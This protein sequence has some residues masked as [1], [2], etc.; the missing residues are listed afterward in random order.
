MCGIAAFF[1]NR[2][3][4][5]L[6]SALEVALDLV[7]HRGP[8]GRGL[9][10][11]RGLACLPNQGNEEGDW[12]LGHV[13]LSILDLTNSGA[14]PMQ[15]GGGRFWISHNGEVYNYQ[16]LK[17]DLLK[18]GYSFR[19]ETDTE[20]ILAAYLEWGEACVEQFVGMFSFVIVDLIKG[21]V[22]LARDRL[23]IKPLYLWQC[24]MGTA[25]VSEPKQLSAFPWFSFQANRQQIADFLSEGV[26]GHE[27][28][29]CCFEGVYPLPAGTT[30]SW[31]LG[32]KPTL[33]QAASY[34]SPSLA[35]NQMSWQQGV[36]RTGELFRDAVKLRMRS[37][38]PVGSCLSGGIDSSS[39]VG[40]VAHEMG[41]QLKTF[42]S[43]FDDPAVDEQIYI[44][45]VNEH[46]GSHPVK[47]FPCLEECLEDLENLV[48]HQDEPF[49]S[50]SIYAQWCVMREARKS[51]VP[52]LLDGQG[53]DE[54][55]CG[56][57]KFAFLYLK[58]LL[59]ERRVGA[60]V[61]N[62]WHLLR[63]GDR[64]LLDFRSG[65]RYLP[66]WLRS[67][68]FT[69]ES[70]LCPEWKKLVRPVWL[71]RAQ[72][73][74]TLREHQL[75]DLKHWSLPILLRYEDRN[76]MA[77]SIESRV[78]FVD[79]R[80][81][82]HCLSLPE[83]FFFKHGKTKRLL[84]ESVKDCLPELVRKRRTKMGFETPQS[85][86]LKG[87]L[88]EMLERKITECQALSEIVDIHAVRYQLFRNNKTRPKTTDNL[89][90]RIS[91]LAVWLDRFGVDV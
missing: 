51:G 33:S 76:S 1:S 37:D 89:L 84:T 9:I 80:F 52:V 3:S 70:F 72:S 66:K 11:G 90:F 55:M 44:D 2:T 6:R 62:A 91:I 28:G 57:R 35:T 42:S 19:S 45:A 13:R 86:W 81:V 67:R 12:G 32:K 7:A 56:Y 83:P 47:V 64:R 65:Q 77:F 54:S 4:T 50:I 26:L 60:L 49:A 17:Q 46:T 40:I 14:Q 87:R 85:S 38:V 25:I 27:F 71:E 41:R 8:D 36:E 24:D 30:L 31:A 78:P 79:H 73:L 58:Q 5:N 43:C 68:S 59:R 29:E 34:W 18:K 10:I 88:G 61:A 74:N 20:V 21:R 53:G 15:S 39:I 63:R 48:Y 75:A 16:E 69:I 22:F 82:E 23:G